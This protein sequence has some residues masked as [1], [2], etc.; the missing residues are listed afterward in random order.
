MGKRADGR[1]ALPQPSTDKHTTEYVEGQG[2]DATPP[3]LGLSSGGSGTAASAHGFVVP[4]LDLVKLD[5]R[6]IC[7]LP[8]WL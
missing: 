7:Y 4:Q 8:A 3:S 5:A 1:I 2:I 6:V